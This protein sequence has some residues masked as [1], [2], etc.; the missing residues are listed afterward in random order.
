MDFIKSLFTLVF[1]LLFI[2]LMFP[3]TVIMWIIA[4]PWGHNNQ[5][6]HRWLT[7]QG[8]VLIAAS[9]LWS[10][11]VSGRENYHH[12]QNYVMVS[13]HQSM[14]DIPLMKCLGMNFRWVSKKENLKVPILGQSM[15]MAGY[16]PIERG[17]KESVIKM[18]ERSEKV[19]NA[20]GSVFI[21]PE[22]SR[23]PDS[24]IHRFKS[25]AFRL[26]VKTNTPILPVIL[27]GTGEVFKGKG[28]VLNSG[29]K[30]KLKILRPLHPPEFATDDP[31]KL[32]SQVRSVM[33]DALEDMRKHERWQDK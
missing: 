28:F 7:F 25:G 15:R 14:L 13:N 10:L 18:M 24:E 27:D 9:P 6:I 12:G 30:L 1:S 20:G 16:I 22:G 5:L 31:D 21:F 3:F 11:K 2:I 17:S 26:A 33:V 8:Q 32:A 4:A 29:H 19:L 23:S